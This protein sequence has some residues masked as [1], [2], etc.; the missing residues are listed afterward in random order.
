MKTTLVTYKAIPRSILEYVS[1]VWLQLALEKNHQP[2]AYNTNTALIIVT[3]CTTYTNTYHLHDNT[4]LIPIKDHLQLH[5][6]QIRHP[7]QNH[8]P[9]H[10][11]T[12]HTTPRQEINNNTEYTT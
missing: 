10:Y 1:T 12:S 8:T 4:H 5:P 2:T 3:W 9:P 6:S 7:S 11:T